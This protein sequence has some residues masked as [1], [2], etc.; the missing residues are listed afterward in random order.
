MKKH[1]FSVYIKKNPYGL[2][3][4]YCFLKSSRAQK[5]AVLY[6]T[7]AASNHQGHLDTIYYPDSISNR[8]IKAFPDSLHRCDYFLKLREAGRSVEGVHEVLCSGESCFSNIPHV[9]IKDWN[10]HA[11][12]SRKVLGERLTNKL[13][14][15]RILNTGIWV[16]EG[17]GQQG[18]H[19]LLITG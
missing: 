19:H 10:I 1:F 12:N 5:A 17:G 16:L 18:H 3:W 7:A 11:E 13:I 6:L 2:T 9:D 15:K 8:K 14:C 4:N